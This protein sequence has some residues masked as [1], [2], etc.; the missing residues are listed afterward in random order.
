[1]SATTEQTQPET[2]SSGIVIESKISAT[3]KV[4][5]YYFHCIVKD[6]EDA[7]IKTEKNLSEK[8]KA[9]LSFVVEL[10]SEELEGRSVYRL[11]S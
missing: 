8:K 6:E 10:T 7:Y 11:I 2:T 3:R 1:M 9:G 5:G 4:D